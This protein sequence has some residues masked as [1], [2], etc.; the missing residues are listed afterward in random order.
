MMTAE[1]ERQQWD[2]FRGGDQ[3]AFAQLFL[4]YYERLF[5]YG[6]KLAAD[7]ELVKDCLQ[8][9]F[10]KL[11][12]R[13]QHLG[14]VTSLQSYLFI[15]LRRQVGDALQRSKAQQ[16][17]AAEPEFEITYSHEDFLISEQLSQ[18]QNEKLQRAL[19]KLS[20]REREALYL[21][22]FDGFS[23]EKI[24]EIMGVNVQ[25]IRNLIYQALQ[26]LRKVFVAVWLFLLLAHHG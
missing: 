6:C 20:K 7:E 12:Q 16:R 26:A 23:Y 15:A 14:A 19:N 11:W 22:F 1:Q 24:A 10:Q 18:E 5:T 3:Q 25:S 13:R 2:D 17:L 4:R 8:E 21:K 9:L